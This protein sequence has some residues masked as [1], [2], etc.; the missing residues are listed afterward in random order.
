M[1]FSTI[2]TAAAYVTYAAGLAMAAA[3]PVPYPI[4]YPYPVAVAVP[5]SVPDSSVRITSS[6]DND[7][8]HIIDEE[9]GEGGVVGE[10]QPDSV[11][12][13][14]SGSGSGSLECSY[15]CSGFGEEDGSAWDN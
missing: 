2:M 1:L 5:D 12:G 8:T 3:L 14:G 11:V 10:N 15:D 9:G 7:K 6:N 4:P 13:S